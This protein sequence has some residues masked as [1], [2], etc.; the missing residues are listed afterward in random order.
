MKSGIIP[1][2]ELG[3]LWTKGEPTKKQRA[4]DVLGLTGGFLLALLVQAPHQRLAHPGHGLH[5]V[6]HLLQLV[7]HHSGGIV[8]DVLGAAD[9]TQNHAA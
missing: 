5:V 6:A 1:I 9:K 3:F 7:Q 2:E 8:H 4:V